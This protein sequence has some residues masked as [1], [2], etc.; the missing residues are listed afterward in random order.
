MNIK[1]KI[2]IFFS[3]ISFICS[4]QDLEPRFLSSVPIKGNFGGVI[5]GYSHGNILLDGSIPIEDLDASLNTFALSYVRSF[6]LFNKL[7]KFDI[8]LPYSFANYS[9]LVEGED[10]RAKRQGIGDTSLRLSIILLGEKPYE[11]KDFQNREQDKFKLGFSFKVRVPTGN[12]DDTK[13]INYGANRWGFLTKVAGSYKF[14]QKFILEAH[15]DSWFFTT[16]ESFLGNELTQKPLISGQINGTYIF[17]Q[18]LWMSLALGYAVNGETSINGEPQNNE[19]NNSRYGFTASYNL[20]KKSALKFAVTNK[21]YTL[22]G[23]DFS[24]YLLGYSFM[25]FDKN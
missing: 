8:T 3:L 9:A 23:A 4:A 19:Q 2:I 17:N 5:Y 10:T 14:S 20:N 21:L 18:K 1:H 24:T 25:W 15:L 13:L 11:L 7:T 22:T 12:Y 16:N 6:S